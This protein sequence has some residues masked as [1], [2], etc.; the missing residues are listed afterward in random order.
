MHDIALPDGR[1]PPPGVPEPRPAPAGAKTQSALRQLSG[2]TFR[3]YE[4]A[5][6]R[7]PDAQLVRAGRAGGL[8]F[9]SLTTDLVQGC[10]PAAQVCYGSCFAA[11]AA[12]ESGYDFGQR[13][14]NLLDTALLLADLEQLPAS[15]R[16]L[17]NGWNS[18][19]SW[20]WPMA[21]VLAM[22]IR[23]SGRLPVFITKYFR[24]LE[25]PLMAQLAGLGAELRISVSAFD[26]PAQTRMRIGAAL[27]YRAAGGIAVPVIMSARFA[28]P[29]H[30]D[31]Q[32]QLVRQ[33]LELD[34]PLAENSLRF[35]PGT[36]VLAAIDLERCSLTADSGE[37]WAGRL[38]ADLKV[39]T[40]TSVPPQYAGL[41]SGYLSRNDGDY[42][43]SLW[44]DPVRSSDEVASSTS[45]RKPVQCGVAKAW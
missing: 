15:Q 9:D 1:Q 42:L 27:A 6:L 2:Q 17:R 41:Q 5:M 22:L 30:R 24:H 12:F 20:R 25:A 34:F 32:D 16:F 13:V 44:R 23:H 14:D 45:Y 43:R 37:Y 4:S 26:S 33:L 11:R 7:R 35:R 31:R 40:L 10:L 19:P 18:D 38:Y 28:D 39:C 36:P 29:A 3:I 8:P 21:V